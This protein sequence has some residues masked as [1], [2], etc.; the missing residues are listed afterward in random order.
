[1]NKVLTTL[2]SFSLNLICSCIYGQGII[3]GNA[4]DSLTSDQL[5]GSEIILTGTAFHAVSNTDGEFIINGIPA[6]DYI[7]QSSYPGYQ[8][9]KYLITVKSDEIKKLNIRLLPNSKNGIQRISAAQ[10]GY[11]D[12]EN[13][14]QAASNS[15]I[16]VIS[17]KSLQ[18]LPDENINIS[19]SRLPGV[20]IL[21]KPVS[22]YFKPFNGG[23]SYSN[24]DLGI[25]YPP[26][27]DF[28]YA[29]DP[30]IAVKLRGLDSRYYNITLDG[31]RIPSTSAR[32]R[33]IDLSMF[34]TRGLNNI[35]L[36]KTITSDEDADATAGV[37][38]LVT[39]KAPGKRIIKGEF[40]GNYN[41]FE[42]STDQYNFTG[43]YSDRFLNKIFG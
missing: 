22:Y 40:L 8:Q 5:K 11:Q 2:V 18:E 7:L 20:F 35:E 4:T 32:D 42:K 29:D 27:D 31:I 3:K 28:F 39:G 33:S 17:G 37:I 43:T 19:L 12:E 1:M 9:K 14:L 21:Y 25:L 38:N 26:R 6:G 23:G 34:S 16:N 13:N 10:A 41:R 15:V 36:H 24:K 30:F